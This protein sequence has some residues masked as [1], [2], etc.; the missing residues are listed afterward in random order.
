VRR[1]LVIGAALAA[2]IALVVTAALVTLP[3]I[4]DTPAM[5]LRIASAAGHALGRPVTFASV[6]V[7]VVPRPAL[8]LKAVE[9]GED[10]AFA[11]T[12]FLTLDQLDVRLRLGPLLRGH[13]VLDS[14]VLQQ[15]HITVLQQAD[16]RV[17]VASLGGTSKALPPVAASPAGSIGMPVTLRGT[18]VQISDGVVL[19][20]GASA[21]GSTSHYWIENLDVTV[22]GGTPVQFEGTGRLQP[23]NLALQITEGTVALNGAASLGEAPLRARLALDTADVT[24]FLP[25]IFGAAPGIDAEAK[26][27][28]ALAGT[29]AAPAASGD[30]AFS[31]V[32]Y[33]RT[34]PRCPEPQRRSLRFPTLTVDAVWQGGQIIGRSAT[35]QF[36]DGTITANLVIRLDEPFR[37]ELEDL[38][39]TEL[40]LEAVLVDFLCTGY[41]VTGP[42]D[43]NGALSFGSAGLVSFGDVRIGPGKVVGEQ[44]LAS[45]ATM[46]RVG[47]AVSALLSADLPWSLFSSPLDFDV[48]TG[49]YQIGS[50]VLTVRDL[51]Y[52]SSAMRISGGGT[53]ALDSGR[54]KFDLVVNHGRGQAYVTVTGTADAPAIHVTPSTILRDVHPWK[55]GQGLRDLFNRLR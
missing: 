14:I 18:R 45:L 52:A 39:L 34:N 24:D 23:G 33:T 35:A 4:L 50:G 25:G 44:A 38:A 53:Y 13:V 16:G 47:G 3:V 1:W 30:L 15:P 8:R 2:G 12:P 21:D 17:S 46:V 29:V 48:L 32:L 26:G 19:Y 54:V 37:I 11:A 10:P 31:E 22:T 42:L 43:L 27:T 49:S 5:R 51:L 9:V 6:S 28:L 41:A 20:F 40:P 36:G 7:T 55:I